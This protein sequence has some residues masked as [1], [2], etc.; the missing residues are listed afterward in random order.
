VARENQYLGIIQRAD[1]EAIEGARDQITKADLG[2]LVEI[3]PKLTNWGQKTAWINLV[4]DHLDA[5]LRPMMMDFLQTPD[6]SLA[7]TIELTK[8]IAVCH[9]EGDLDRF[10]V[11]LDD[12]RLL[13]NRV[14][15]LLLDAPR[16][17]DPSALIDKDWR[18]KKESPW[19]VWGFAILL[20]GLAT[21]ALTAI[22]QHTLNLYRIRGVTAQGRVVGRW[23]DDGDYCVEVSYFD[24]DILEGGELYFAEI[25]EF[26]SQEIWDASHY[27]SRVEIVFLPKNSERNTILAASLEN[28]QL[29]PQYQYQLFGPITGVGM[30]LLVIWRVTEYIKQKETG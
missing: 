19:M 1:F 16:A 12:R 15:D 25:C 7:E 2:A 24:K 28:E 20:I 30:L 18:R 6:E 4:Q 26:I 8:A 17:Q 13:A 23:E 21:L 10:I 22:N 29:S 5:R 27:D 11:Y 14:Y 9:L 3:Y